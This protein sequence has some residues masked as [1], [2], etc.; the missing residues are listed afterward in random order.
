MDKPIGGAYPV[1]ERVWDWSFKKRSTW[2]W[3]KHDF[4][5]AENRDWEPE[6]P[7]KMPTNNPWVDLLSKQPNAPE[8]KQKCWPCVWKYDKKYR[9]GAKYVYGK[10]FV[11][12][13][14]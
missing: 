12:K 11:D 3:H 9:S 2:R 7:P 8:T 10:P 13:A 6:N 14:G 5:G 4:V 1:K